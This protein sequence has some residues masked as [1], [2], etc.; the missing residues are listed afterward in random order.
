MANK[1]TDAQKRYIEK[2]KPGQRATG[3]VK[4]FT[5]FGAFVS[6]GLVNGLVH[7]KN[8]KWGRVDDPSEHLRIGQQ[9][10][11]IILEVDYEKHR[12]SLGIKQLLEDPWEKFSGRF[13]SGDTIAANVIAHKPFGLI[14]E[15]VPGITA[16]LHHSATGDDISD[17]DSFPVGAAFE[18]IITELIP[19][20]RT[21]KVGLK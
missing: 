12:L 8:I 16:L 7:N 21:L 2:L 14:M 1:L 13:K 20:T 4:T 15:V 10:E 9:V 19:E 18:V 3:K 6:I 17:T 5:D 11:V